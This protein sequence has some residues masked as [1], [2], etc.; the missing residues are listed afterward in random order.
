[1][2]SPTPDLHCS[3]AAPTARACDVE[4]SNDLT[5]TIAP[6][7]A[8]VTSINAPTKSSLWSEMDILCFAATRAEC[9]FVVATSKMIENWC[10]G[11]EKLRCLSLHY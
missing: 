6:P 7:A 2:Y 3:R 4:S 10:W 8:K 11:K 1:M 9:D 5:N